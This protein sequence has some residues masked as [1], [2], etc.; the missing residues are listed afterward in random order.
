MS[1]KKTN[2][3][4]TLNRAHHIYL[5]CRTKK[6]F[7]PT[8]YPSF[9]TTLNFRT[10]LISEP[11]LEFQIQQQQSSKFLI[12]LCKRQRATRILKLSFN[13]GFMGLKP[14]TKSPPTCHQFLC[15][16]S[17]SFTCHKEWFSPA[18]TLL[19]LYPSW[20]SAE[21][22]DCFTL[23]LQERWSRHSGASVNY[24]GSIS[25]T[26]RT[27]KSPKFSEASILDQIP[28]HICVLINPV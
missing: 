5:S 12:W 26:P 2:Q 3:I 9:Q 20:Q 19:K 1:S 13:P 23:A 14:G 18:N 17:K 22:A 6:N 7:K 25:A 10:D 28:F 15:R 21:Q 11:E 27:V 24:R 4:S 16:T 8:F